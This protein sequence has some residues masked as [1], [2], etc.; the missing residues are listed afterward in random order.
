MGGQHKPS[1]RPAVGGF[2]AA[3]ALLVLGALYVAGPLF[4][5][6]AITIVIVMAISQELLSTK[7]PPPKPGRSL[8]VNDGVL[9]QYD[10]EHV[11][12]KIDLMKPFQ[13]RVVDQ[14]DPADA[15]FKLFQ[16]DSTLLF[17]TSDPGAAAIV[18]DVIQIAWPPQTRHAGRSYP[19]NPPAA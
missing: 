2:A 10:G 4:F 14:Y 3:T 15:I 7:E 12:A 13:Y 9:R 8:Q 6:P 5:Y 19:P 17:R 11:V 18:S 16:A 1:R